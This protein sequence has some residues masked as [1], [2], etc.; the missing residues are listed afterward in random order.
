MLHPTVCVLRRGASLGPP[1]KE[2][3]AGAGAD[4]LEEGDDG[5][6]YHQVV[7]PHVVEVLAAARALEERIGMLTVELSELRQKYT[8]NDRRV[9]DKM[10][11]IEEL[12]GRVGEQPPRIVGTERF[13]RKHKLN[14]LN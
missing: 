4:D 1:S 8:A 3:S 11:Q 2:A 9:Q 6:T 10:R 5:E 7:R 12:R 14:V 13:E